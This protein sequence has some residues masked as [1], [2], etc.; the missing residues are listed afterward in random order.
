MPEG[1]THVYCEIATAPYD[2]VGDRWIWPVY[3]LFEHGRMV[4]NN[5][6]LEDGWAVAPEPLL[7]GAPRSGEVVSP[8]NALFS[9]DR[10]AC[11]PRAVSG[12]AIDCLGASAP[13][14]TFQRRTIASTALFV[15]AF[16]HPRVTA[17]LVTLRSDIIS[18]GL[19]Q[20]FANLLESRLR[21]YWAADICELVPM[22]VLSVLR[23][24][25]QNREYMCA[26]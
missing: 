13:D 23:S 4:Q 12:F 20:T 14:V 15:P 6:G 11:D 10:A 18:N 3:V 22:R 16:G 25:P 5:A 26:S 24:L 9:L 17:T 8:A 19:N 2:P 1:T 7:S 21:A